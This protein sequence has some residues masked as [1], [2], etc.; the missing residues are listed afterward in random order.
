MSETEVESHVVV[1]QR[2]EGGVCSL[3]I[4]DPFVN[5]AVSDDLKT[6]LKT[7]CKAK[8]DEGVRRFVLDLSFVTVMDSCGLSVLISAKKTVEGEGGRIYMAAA[9]SMLQRLFQITKLDRV[10]ETYPDEE[11]A[12]AALQAAA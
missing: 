6:T 12:A 11:A 8:L 5:Y 4:R 3:Q 9:S 2:P 1:R 7:I 10:F